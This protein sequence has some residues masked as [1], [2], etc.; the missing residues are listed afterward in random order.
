MR[1]ART[2]FSLLVAGVTVLGASFAAERK[3]FQDW[4]AGTS[5]RA[6]LDKLQQ[7]NG[8]FF[9]APDS[10]YYWSRGNGWMA[11]GMA[12]LLRALPKKHP[13]H[14]RILEGYRR[15]MASLLRYQGED[16]LWPVLPR[17]PAQRR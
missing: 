1:S 8:L 11:A 6:Y 5:P 17:S 2:A 7:P 10:P 12:E 4:P 14:A 15:M 13:Q 16:G 3:E 9:H